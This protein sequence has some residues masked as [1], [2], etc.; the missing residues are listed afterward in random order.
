MN[1]S[2]NGKTAIVTGAGKKDGIG[3]SFAG[4]LAEAGASVMLAD[5]NA[6]DVAARAAELKDKGY[7]VA[8]TRVDISDQSSVEA[9]V[10]LAVD[11]FG[12]L[13]IIVNNAAIMSELSHGVDIIDYPVDEWR[14]VLDINLTGTMFCCRAAAHQMKKQGGGKIINISSGGAFEPTTPYSISKLG[15]VGMTAILGD[16][17][18]KHN[19]NVNSI[20]PG[21]TET[22]AGLSMLPPGSPHR[23]KRIVLRAGSP[24]D[25]FGALLLLA[26]PAGDWITGQTLNVDGGWIKRI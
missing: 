12:G 8:S 21:V 15:V 18:A 11:T 9:M 10:K 13:D 1:F 26:S 22:P 14:R 25:M 16:Q 19:I 24:A 5:I 6:G 17:L 7:K 2:L 4:A 20:A 3:V 23:D